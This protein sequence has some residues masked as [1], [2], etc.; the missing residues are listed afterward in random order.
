MPSFP[1]YTFLPMALTALSR[2]GHKHIH[3]QKLSIVLPHLCGPFYFSDTNP[4]TPCNDL[5]FSE[6]GIKRK[7]DLHNAYHLIHK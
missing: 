5:V 1:F 4:V 7:L 3:G 2:P 6:D